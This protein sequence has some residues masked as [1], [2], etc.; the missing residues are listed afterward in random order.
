MKRILA[1][2]LGL[3]AVGLIIVLSSAFYNIDERENVVITRFGKPVRSMIQKPG[4]HIKTPFVEDVNRFSDQLLEW[5]GNPEQIPTKDKKY[6][7]VDT[8]A[9]WKIVDPLKFFRSVVN[10]GEAQSRLDNII[11][12]ATRDYITDYSLIEVVRDTNREMISTEK[13][14]Q[15]TH[16]ETIEKIKFGRNKITRGILS[17]AS[18]IVSEYGI[19]LVDIR[20]K[21]INYIK[22]VQRKV[23][24]RMISERKRIAEKYR[25]EGKGKR[26]EIEGEK[27]KELKRITSEAYKNAQEVIGKADAEAT[28]IYASAFNKDPDFYSFLQTLDTY[29]DTIDENSWLIMSTDSDYFKYLKGY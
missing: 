19:D 7:L 4:L 25:S 12:A 3:I 27:E 21:R 26:S 29:K 20:I 5:D 2:I 9:R 13:E 11:E 17:Q 8:T 24:D 1:P 22:N 10:E 28:N 16:V 23:F 6:I 15:L 14:I 18:K